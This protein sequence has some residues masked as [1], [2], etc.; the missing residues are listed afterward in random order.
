MAKLSI[1]LAAALTA[2]LAALAASRFQLIQQDI[3]RDYSGLPPWFSF[4]F[5]FKV[6]VTQ[7]S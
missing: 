7:P 1:G 3:M 5:G 2:C 4:T 6:Q